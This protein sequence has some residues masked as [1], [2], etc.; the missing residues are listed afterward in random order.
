ML[1]G[2]VVVLTS[3]AYLGLLFAIAYYADQRADRGRSV[4]ASPYIYSLS[5]AVYATAWT[6]Y[7]SVGRAASDGVG[8]LPIYI[9]PTLM[10]A[11]WWIVMRKIL[12]ISKANR[13]TS[14]ADF[15]ASRY[16]K[17]ALLGGVVT[18]IAVIGIL[19]Y[20]SLQLKAVS[21]SFTIIMQYPAIVMP[22]TVGAL[23]V[24]Q[25]TALWMALILALFTI[26]FGTRHLDVAEHHEGMVAAIAFESLVKL[27]AFL[28]VGIF[29]TFGIYGGFGDVFARVR[30]DPGLAPMLT[31]LDGVAGSYASWA[32]LTILSMLAIMFLPRQFQVAVIENKDETHLKKAI[33]L[34]PLYMLA[35]N[36]FVL[37]IAFG[38]RMHF[39]GGNVDAD[40]FVLTLPM[41][42]KQ[43]WLAL[44]VFIGGLSAATGMV[45]VET[46]ALSTMV[47]NDLVMPVLLRLKRLRLAERPDLTGLLLAIRRGAIVAI[48]LLG[49][50]YFRL[51]GEAYAL[52]SIGLISFA[53]VAQF[54]P[55]VFG[56]IFWKNGTRR[57]A[58]AGLTAGFA[59]WLYTLLL[60]ALA[61]S[62]W[63]PR[64]FVEH[65]PFGI[66]LLQPLALFGLA[67]LD[68]ITHSMIWSMIAN[69]G[70]YVLVSLLGAPSAEEHRQ[71]SVFVDVFHREGG[72]A[73]F[74][75]GIAS[76]PDLHNVLARFIG[77]AAADDAVSEYARARGR[78]WPDDKIEADA[79]FV[80][81]VE[82]Q[83][84]GAIG[85]ASARVMV[86]SAV[87]EEALTLDEVREILDEASEV[88]IY[89]HKLE[90]KSHELEKA[91]T[92]LRAANERLQEV[93][94]LK[95]DF[96]STVTHE[97]RT[98]LTSIRAFSAILLDDPNIDSAQ[99][100]RF[101]SIIAKEAERLTR[102]INQVL[103]LAK[104]ESGSAEW[105]VTRVDVKEIVSDTLSR[106]SSVFKEKG[107]EVET[108]FPDRLPRV[109]ADLDR[110]VQVL[111]N[112][113]SNAVKFC[114]AR[115]GR[116]ALELSEGAGVVRVDIRD[117]GPGI[118]PE[119]QTVIFQKF[120]QAGDTMTSKPQGTGLGLHISRQIVEHFG[121]KLW[122]ESRRGEGAC[123]SFTLPIDVASAEAQIA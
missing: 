27:L 117:N 116:I 35:I 87:K 66:E 70:A 19:P 106:M 2:W 98:P 81:F 34:F 40:T 23:P 55:A 38:G 73:R 17:S 92:E 57:G 42:E 102:L 82:V 20:I 105:C 33:W 97:L 108:Q 3:F 120:R 75:R 76:V 67:G 96:M 99:L 45:I 85:G 115:N 77:A 56:G 122:V 74:W 103:D 15:I 88:V 39:A 86:A 41:A 48:L 51:A 28:A 72:G 109:N 95:D 62:D 114:Q 32:W 78:H 69:I 61:R 44:L 37:P 36:V 49:Y 91:T 65:G 89:S 24:L 79:D 68:Q 9:G 71:A 6:F 4:I 18:L 54:A 25:D 110:L 8:F 31:P 58:L 10:I 26:L 100:T 64:G 111:M 94:R 11:L 123:F 13:I 101:V 22:A 21:N 50:L 43:E 107:I 29:V 1:Q 59:V 80:H 84:A 53:A 90:Q 7:G 14:L 60:P 63:L 12:R 47:C 5:L 113:L 121:G 30:A 16:G 118:N 104:I 112:L 93:D 52:V 83:L 119:D 46:I